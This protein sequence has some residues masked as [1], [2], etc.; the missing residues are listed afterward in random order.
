MAIRNNMALEGIPATLIDAFFADPPKGGKH[1]RKKRRPRRR[2]NT[3][4]K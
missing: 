4:R 1:T 3:K 2:R